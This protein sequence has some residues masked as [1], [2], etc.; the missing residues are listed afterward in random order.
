MGK[1]SGNKV[2]KGWTGSIFSGEKVK[3][4]NPLAIRKAKNLKK[5]TCK[6]CAIEC[7]MGNAPFPFLWKFRQYLLLTTVSV[8]NGRSSKS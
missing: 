4:E 2:K 6:Q 7:V 3:T 5:K 8:G 1:R